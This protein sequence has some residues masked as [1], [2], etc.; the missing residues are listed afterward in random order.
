M[1]R[2]LDLFTNEVRT[3]CGTPTIRGYENGVGSEAKFKQP[4]GIALNNFSP[5]VQ[6]LYVSD[7]RNHAIRRISLVGSN[8]GELEVYRLFV[9]MKRFTK[10]SLDEKR[11]FLPYGGS[12]LIP[13][14]NIFMLL[15]VGI[16]Q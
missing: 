2:S 3:L 1:V 16:I 5:K 12:P 4:S 7:T 8:R 9:E 15:I 11:S 6:E 13:F 14:L 10:P